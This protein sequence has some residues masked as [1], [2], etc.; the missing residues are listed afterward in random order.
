MSQDRQPTREFEEFSTTEE[1]QKQ[2]WNIKD[3]AVTAFLL[4]L[5]VSLIAAG[6]PALLEAYLGPVLA[7]DTSWITTGL[8]VFILIVAGVFLFGQYR[9]QTTL[10]KQIYALLFYLAGEVPPSQ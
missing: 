10:T 6:I 4:A 3:I 5:A 2:I 7:F 1:A 9:P 8:G